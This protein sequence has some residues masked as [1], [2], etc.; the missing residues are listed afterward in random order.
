MKTIKQRWNKNNRPL[1]CTSSFLGLLFFCSRSCFICILLFGKH[2]LGVYGREDKHTVNTMAEI[3][4][5][6]C[7]LNNLPVFHWV[8]ELH[9]SAHSVLIRKCGPHWYLKLNDTKSTSCLTSLYRQHVSYFL[10]KQSGVL[11]FSSLY[12]HYCMWVF[13]FG[14]PR[15]C[16]K[17]HSLSYFMGYLQNTQACLG[18]V[19]QKNLCH[20]YSVLKDT[21][22][23]LKTRC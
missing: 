4:M 15:I 18:L 3:G 23:L 8:W 2:D 11:S 22:A 13:S 19:F 10:S 17:H 20:S 6:S 12:S 1:A 9:Q 7:I 21:H 5:D 14:A 16:Q